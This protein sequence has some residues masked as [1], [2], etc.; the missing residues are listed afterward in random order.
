MN[1]VKNI[2]T[3]EDKAYRY[4]KLREYMR[5]Q[6]LDA[7][8][9]SGDGSVK[10]L[11]GEFFSPWHA[12]VLAPL[13]GEPAV[14]I[15]IEGREYQLS[16]FNKHKDD[17][18]IKDARITSID[19]ICSA[20]KE[21]GLANSVIGLTLFEF[22]APLFMALQKALPD[23]RF[24]DAGEGFQDLRR[25]HSGNEIKLIRGSVNVVDECLMELPGVIKPG[26]YET[27][28]WGFLQGKMAEMGC[29]DT[30]NLI[31]VDPYD[32]SAVTQPHSHAPRQIKKG[33]LLAVEVTACYRGYWSQ[34]IA[35]FSI[36]KPDAQV[37]AVFDASNAGLW[38]AAEM[39][40]PG[41]NVKDMLKAM[42]D[43]IESEGFL[44]PRQFTTGPQGHL[45]SVDFKD[46][47]FFPD[48]DYILEEG[49]LFVLHPGAAVHGWTPG[50][51]GI[52]GP[53]TMFLVTKDGVESLNKVPN[54][55]VIID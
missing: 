35:T 44:S 49:M 37:Q 39:A 1:N 7:V 33:D 4:K 29:E 23:V 48:E 45:C 9:C 19:N 13:D 38:K 30:L 20:I 10:Y 12:F 16:P 36:G 32:I 17:Y 43:T 54:E 2:L 28:I 15:A 14:F 8:L 41:V 34:K 6:G 42:D 24:V 51:L 55:L 40:G 3:Q 27:D 31:C 25:R 21:K 18:W 47:T 22:P 53:G 52:F 26:I 46:I 5:S 11:A 50:K